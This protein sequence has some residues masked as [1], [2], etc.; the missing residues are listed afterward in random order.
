M[1]ELYSSLIDKLILG[2]SDHIEFYRKLCITKLSELLTERPEQEDRI[3]RQL[4]FKLGDN[5][6]SV[7]THA[8]SFIVKL[9]RKHPVM[10]GIV[11]KEVKQFME[12]AK[13]NG[14][15]YSISLINSVIFYEED[16]DEITEIVQL[17]FARFN[18][19][20][21][22]RSTTDPFSN[23]IMG[24]ILKGVTKIAE[25]MDKGSLETVLNR[26]SGDINLLFKVSHSQ[27]FKIRVQTLTLIFQFMKI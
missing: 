5:D 24:L 26:V 14:I 20:T 2:T 18:K 21:Q 19:L 4:V 12:T 10:C 3:L 23:Q 13:P 27:T 11:V 9:L 7:S 22:G 17:Y 1:K 15:Y 8:L 6:K 16:L 25:H